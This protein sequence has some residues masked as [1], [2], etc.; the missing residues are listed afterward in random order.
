MFKRVSILGAGS[1]GMAIARLLEHNGLK[2]TLWEFNEEDCQII[3][4]QR[5]HPKKLPNVKLADSIKVTN[6]IYEAILD[7][8]LIILSIPSQSL[9]SALKEIPSKTVKNIPMINLAKGIEIKSLKRMSE[10]ITEELNHPLELTMTLSGPSHAEE[11]ASDIPTAVVLAGTDSSLTESI[12]RIF[13][14]NSFSRVFDLDQP[15]FVVVCECVVVMIKGQVACL[16]V[17]QGITADSGVFIV[18]IGIV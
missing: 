8:E 4:Q 12:Q 13:S 3:S 1:W 17:C 10:V 2:V 15:V 18:R 11:V 9:R 14:N 7:T 5:C 16:I 6:D